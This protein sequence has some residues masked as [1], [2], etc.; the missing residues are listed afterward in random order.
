M[1]P[2][3]WHR[4]GLVFLFL[5]ASFVVQ[6]VVPPTGWAGFV[7]VALL[8]ATL[9]SAFL[10]VGVRMWVMRL[11][12]I[13][14]AAVIVASFVDL[15]ASG[16]INEAAVRIF[17]GLMVALVPPALVV[18][19]LRSIRKHGAVTIEAV[20]GVLCV[21]VLI[22]MFFA[23]LYGA[24]DRLGGGPVFVT[25]AP[26]TSANCL[27]FS[28]TTLTTVGYGDLTTRTDLLHTLAVTEALFGQIYLVTVVS[29]I[30]SNLG[31]RR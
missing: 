25:G 1:A 2:A 11:T 21:Y 12:M 17:N 10:A 26:A 3:G 9:V 28:F 29:V 4:F 6:G 23:F 18:G 8:G 24:M 31:R 15:L 20:L 30:V 13:L 5:A 7:S 22:G 19:V 14:V 16:S 27:Y